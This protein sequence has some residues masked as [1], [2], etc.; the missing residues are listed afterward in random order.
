MLTRGIRG[1]SEGS[2]SSGQANL[3]LQSAEDIMIEDS[4]EFEPMEILRRDP[5][6]NLSQAD[7]LRRQLSQSERSHGSL[8]PSTITCVQELARQYIA[9]GEYLKAELLYKRAFVSITDSDTRGPWHSEMIRVLKPL[10]SVQIGQGKF[11]AATENLKYLQTFEVAKHGEESSQTLRT[12]ACLAI[13][14]DKQKRWQDAESTYRAVIQIQEKRDGG[15]N[16]EETLAIMEH[17]GLSY[18]LQGRK[19]LRKAAKQY[20]EVLCRRKEN[21]DVLREEI[22]RS[23]NTDQDHLN[24]KLNHS[25]GRM[26]ATVSKLVEVCEAMGNTKRRLE[27]LEEN[28]NLVLSMVMDTQR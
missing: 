6:R 18:R 14:Y 5:S 23:S 26:S 11:A 4:S 12:R 27:L 3:Q 21:L 2:G 28:H 17:L 24:E 25:E 13:L 22:K 1:L 16:K 7:A 19:T 20:E 15:S 10:A 9:D 8:H